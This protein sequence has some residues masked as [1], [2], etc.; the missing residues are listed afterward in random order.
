MDR[1]WIGECSVVFYYCFLD[2]A[3]LSGNS[4]CQAFFTCYLKACWLAFE[5]SIGVRRLLDLWFKAVQDKQSLKGFSIIS[6]G[7]RRTHRSG[8][9]KQNPEGSILLAPGGNL[10]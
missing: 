6:V 8:P 5:R 4:L 1:S 2:L 10:G 9:S 7:T 3:W